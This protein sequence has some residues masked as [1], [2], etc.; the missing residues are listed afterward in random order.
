MINEKTVKVTLSNLNICNVVAGKETRSTCYGLI[1][2][3]VRILAN[4]NVRIDE[5]SIQERCS[6]LCN[7]IPRA[8]ILYC[9]KS[10][11]SCI[12]KKWSTKNIQQGDY[13]EH[14]WSYLWQSENWESCLIIFVCLF[15]LPWNLVKRIQTGFTRL[16]AVW[17]LHFYSGWNLGY[18]CKID[19]A[20]R[21]A[22]WFRAVVSF[23][24]HFC[25]NLTFFG[26]LCIS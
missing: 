20:T 23:R 11:G 14:D 7:N 16:V 9:R 12:T 4:I 13:G 10:L 25:R 15:S 2:F 18:L 5:N 26:H 21:C 22:H 6:R 8:R 17:H 1:L 3:S 24:Y 19:Q